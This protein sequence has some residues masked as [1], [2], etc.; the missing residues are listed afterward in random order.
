MD[1]KQS[2]HPLRTRRRPLG[3]FAEP[4]AEPTRDGIRAC[5]RD[6][7]RHR[8]RRLRKPGQ[9]PGGRGWNRGG[10]ENVTSL[11]ADVRRFLQCNEAVIAESRHNPRFIATTEG[12]TR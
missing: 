10:T 11:R 2:S 8:D 6:R 1:A 4:E 9:A 5:G 3:L 7:G 12:R